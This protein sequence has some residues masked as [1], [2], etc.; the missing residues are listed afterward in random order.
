MTNSPK[1]PDIGV[2]KFLPESVRFLAEPAI[3]FSG[4]VRKGFSEAEKK[5]LEQLAVTCRDGNLYDAVERFLDEYHMTKYEESLA[6]FQLFGAMDRL[7]LSYR[8]YLLSFVADPERHMLSVH[9]D[10]NG[11]NA[12]IERLE[13]IRDALANDA[14]EHDHLFAEDGLTSSKLVPNESDYAN[15]GHVKVY[16]WNDEWAMKHGLRP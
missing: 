1:K 4:K 9:M 14:C 12:L 16:G 13:L 7:K 8:K 5:E 15:I 11:A 6:L 10:L 2:L 3:R